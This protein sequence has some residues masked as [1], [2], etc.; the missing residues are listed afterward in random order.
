VVGEEL[1]RDY[2]DNRQ[3]QFGSSR[4]EEYIV[5]D[6]GNLRIALRGDRDQAAVPR[7]NFLHD[8]ESPAITQH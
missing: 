3:Q 8:V 1:Q 5:G 7:S 4:D 6:A 2:F